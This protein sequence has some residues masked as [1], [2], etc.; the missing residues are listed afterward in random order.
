MS[1]F[2]FRRTYKKG[3]SEFIGGDPDHRLKS[4]SPCFPQDPRL[5]Q[6]SEIRLKARRIHPLHCRDQQ[7]L[8]SRRPIQ[9]LIK[10]LSDLRHLRKVLSDW[11][12][13]FVTAVWPAGPAT[14]GV[15]RTQDWT[16]GCTRYRDSER[17]HIG[18]RA[19][20][21][22]VQEVYSIP[23]TTYPHTP[24]PHTILKS[25]QDPGATTRQTQPQKGS[26]EKPC[27]FH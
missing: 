5:R 26:F 8:R 1:P 2:E 11:W 24:N 17:P 20:Q 18:R 10:N 4:T 7:P 25:R 16:T 19:S 14:P 22:P 13:Y 27:F 12:K 9:Q 23:S 3:R 15:W 6:P 21:S